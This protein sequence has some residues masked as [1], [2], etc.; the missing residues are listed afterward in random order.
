MTSYIYLLITFVFLL[1]VCFFVVCVCSTGVVTML[2][3]IYTTCASGEIRTHD[4][5]GKGVENGLAC[6]LPIIASIRARRERY[7]A[8]RMREK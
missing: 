6:L 7:K 5:T 8:T 4:I 1:S 3:K 2:A